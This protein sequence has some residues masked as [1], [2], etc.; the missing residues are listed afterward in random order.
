MFHRDL[1]LVLCFLLYLLIISPHVY[2]MPS[3]MFFD[4]HTL[5]GDKALAKI[6]QLLQNALNEA[7]EWFG[8]N[9]STLNI[10]KCNPLIIQHKYSRQHRYF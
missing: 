6:Q 8:Q 1:H 7:I 3:V 9:N 10:Y 5:I 4:D 2:Q